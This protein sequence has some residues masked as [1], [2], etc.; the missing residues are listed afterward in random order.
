VVLPP[1]QT[2]VL[3]PTEAVVQPAA[4]SPSIPALAVITPTVTPPPVKCTGSPC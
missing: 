4:A 1:T 2:V 3:P